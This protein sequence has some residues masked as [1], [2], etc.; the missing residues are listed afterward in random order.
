MNEK[1]FRI[2]FIFFGIVSLIAVWIVCS[3]CASKPAVIVDTGDI[4]RLRSELEYYRGECDRLQRDNSRIIADGQ[5]Y[6]DYYQ[7]ATEAIGAGIGE[8]AVLGADSLSEIARLRSYITVLRNIV[9][10]IIAGE[11]REGQQDSQPN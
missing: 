7:S 8:L 5:F 2:L 10:S 3:G 6:A 11:Q 9:D 1:V 4:E